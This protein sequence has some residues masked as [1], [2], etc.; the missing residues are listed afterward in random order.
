MMLV[1]CCDC[2]VAES[3]PPRVVRGWRLAMLVGVDEP[4]GLVL[5]QASRSEMSPDITQAIIRHRCGHACRRAGNPGGSRA[6]G[7]DGSNAGTATASES[8]VGHHACDGQTG[9]TSTKLISS[10]HTLRSTLGMRMYGGCANN[11]ACNVAH[12]RVQAFTD[13][14]APSLSAEQYRLH[15]GT[16]DES[17]TGDRPVKDLSLIHI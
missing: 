6:C 5:L 12:G 2:P 8:K 11:V 17:R 3:P 13:S 15:C 14:A 10:S 4:V 9:V 7:P 16:A 1:S